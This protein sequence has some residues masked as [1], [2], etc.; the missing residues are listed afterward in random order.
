[1]PASCTLPPLPAHMPTHLPPARARPPPCARVHRLQPATGGHRPRRAE[2]H[3]L[4]AG[5]A[6]P[7]PRTGVPRRGGVR[8]RAPVHG[9]REGDGPP[10]PPEGG[11]ASGP[12]HHRHTASTTTATA[13]SSAPLHCDPAAPPSRATL[14]HLYPSLPC[15]RVPQAVQDKLKTWVKHARTWHKSGGAPSWAREVKMRGAEWV[16]ST[17]QRLK[18][19]SVPGLEAKADE[20]MP[21]LSGLD[22]M[23][24]RRLAELDAKIAELSLQERAAVV[25]CLRK[26]KALASTILHRQ[27]ELAF[28]A[29]TPPTRLILLFTTAGMGPQRPATK[30]PLAAWAKRHYPSAQAGAGRARPPTRT[31]RPRR[32]AAST[33]LLTCR[34]E[35]H[36]RRSGSAAQQLHP[37]SRLDLLK[38]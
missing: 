33:P 38:E 25:V 10:P 29:S 34:T 4:P 2:E 24:L 3:S 1:M 20:A 16:S 35:Q 12:R 21:P 36:L 18:E 32:A 27:L 26:L 23:E 31:P 13:A 22:A 19:L 6:R 9:E 17:G 37:L 7:P 11:R 14:P 8:E 15:L 5:E 30:T 28:R